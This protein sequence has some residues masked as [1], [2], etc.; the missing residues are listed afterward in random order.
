M[1]KLNG[2]PGDILFFHGL[3]NNV[4]VLSSLK[5]INDLMEKR[6]QNYSHRPKFV[7]ACDLV[8]GDRVCIEMHSSHGFLV[9]MRI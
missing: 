4:L 1:A 5:A 9:F 6:S 2:I 8:G 7:F 3:G